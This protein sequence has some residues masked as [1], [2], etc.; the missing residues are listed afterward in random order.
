M[1]AIEGTVGMFQAVATRIVRA[2]PGAWSTAHDA[3]RWAQ[4]EP[5]EPTTQIP[6]GFPTTS[7]AAVIGDE[8]TSLMLLV[9]ATSGRRGVGPKVMASTC[10]RRRGRCRDLRRCSGAAP[11]VG[12]DS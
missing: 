12:C 10:D 1:G 9:H 4:S 6:D 3:A 2:R 8:L 5:S 7:P 11:S